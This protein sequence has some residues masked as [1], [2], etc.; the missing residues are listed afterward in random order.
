[1]YFLKSL[2]NEVKSAQL[3]FNRLSKTNQLVSG[4]L[5]ASLAA[6]FQ[7]AG[8]FLP[9]IGIFISPLSTAPILFCFVLSLPLGFITYI[10]TNLLLLVIQPSELIIF[11]FT[12]GILGMGIGAAFYFFKKR[13]YII[14]SGATLLTFGI[15]TLLYVFKFPVLVPVI[16]NNFSLSTTGLIFVF[17][18]LYSWIWVELSL[19]YFKKL[20]TFNSL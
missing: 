6:L 1:M 4:A 7:S 9:G 15:I 2:S 17:T 3:L 18:F 5:F 20:K 8:G 13:L 11:P 19:A 10:L 14:I 16:S 12:T